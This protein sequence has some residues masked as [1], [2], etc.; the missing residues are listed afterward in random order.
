ME[1]YGVELELWLG[2]VAVLGAAAL[3]AMR[4]YQE[5]NADGKITLDE[6]I[7]IAEEGEEH[8]DAIADEVEKIEEAMSTRKCSVCGNTGHDKRNCPDTESESVAVNPDDV[9]I[10]PG[11][12]VGYF[13]P[14]STAVVEVRLDHVEAEVA[15]HDT[16]IERL[17]QSHVETKTGLA[18]I[19]SE[20]KVTNDLLSDYMSTMQ[21]VMFALIAI[22]AAAMGMSTFEMV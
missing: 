21:K 20:L 19:T 5:V 14:S 3:W 18:S 17:V 10:D 2:L 22:V 15:R 6:V 13:M 1:I 8:A 9:P 16:V 11:L 7:N 12:R 4:K